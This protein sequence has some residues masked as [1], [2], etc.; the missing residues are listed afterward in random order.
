VRVIAATNRD[1]A[2][3]VASG[4]FR[5]D[6]YYR[7]NVV[8]LEL[9]SLSERREDIPL[10]AGY[11]LERYAKKLGKKVTRFT[12]EAQALLAR[13]DYPGN[14]RE[15]EN[16]I[17]RAVTLAES[18]TIVASDLPPSFTRTRLLPEGVPI[19]ADARE[20]WSLEEVEQ[21]HI[22]R[23]LRRHRGNLA[24]AARQLGIS[25]STLWRKMR[26]YRIA[27]PVARGRAGGGNA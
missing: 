4:A 26:R 9:P 23:V 12:P 8:Q 18:Q 5:E 3:S 14:V 16:A 10:L 17:E 21:E 22:E 2:Q 27:R 19:S 1:L 6:L 25:R 13:H 20:T 7:L 15:L 24:N 11:F